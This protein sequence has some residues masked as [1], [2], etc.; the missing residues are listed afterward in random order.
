MFSVQGY[1]TVRIR[2]CPKE[3]VMGQV[4]QREKQSWPVMQGAPHLFLALFLSSC[5]A[6]GSSL[7]FMELRCL[8][9]ILANI[10]L[11]FTMYQ[12]LC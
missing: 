11:K 9:L 2:P 3:L 4:Q 8:L 6:L 1:K 10:M 7:P 5:K 12:A